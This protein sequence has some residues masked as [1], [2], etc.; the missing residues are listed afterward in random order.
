MVFVGNMPYAHGSAERRASEMYFKAVYHLQLSII[1]YNVE[2]EE[3][4]KIT[5]S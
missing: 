2:N 3:M 5:P 1:Q 4:E